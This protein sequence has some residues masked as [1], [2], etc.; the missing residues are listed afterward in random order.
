MHLLWWFSNKVIYLKHS[1]YRAADKAVQLARLY[2]AGAPSVPKEGRLYCRIM[3]NDPLDAAAGPFFM[4]PPFPAA[5][6]WSK[7]CYL[8]PIWSFTGAQEAVSWRDFFLIRSAE[9]LTPPRLHLLIMTRNFR[10]WQSD[11]GYSSFFT[12]CLLQQRRHL[13]QFSCTCSMVPW[14]LSM[15]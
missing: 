5:A 3:D 4:F 2:S 12:V 14:F 10:P 13:S 9:G 15:A 8:G 6:G 7:S 1:W 11:I